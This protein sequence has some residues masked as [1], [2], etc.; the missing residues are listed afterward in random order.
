MRKRNYIDKYLLNFF[1]QCNSL[2][3]LLEILGNICSILEL[4]YLNK[5]TK[6]FQ[7]FQFT[8]FGLIERVKTI[9]GYMIF[10]GESLKEKYAELNDIYSKLQ[11]LQQ[12]VFEIDEFIKE[13]RQTKDKII[14]IS[15]EYAKT[16]GEIN[17]FIE[18]YT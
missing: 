4:K 18:K 6:H 5:R 17:K 9:L 7:Y 16:F 2:K 3:D 8:F 14:E 12:K 1:M 13:M 10:K 11:Q 15:Q